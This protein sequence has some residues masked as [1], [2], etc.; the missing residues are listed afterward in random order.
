[1]KFAILKFSSS[2]VRIAASVLYA[3][4]AAAAV[5]PIDARSSAAASMTERSIAAASDA[6]LSRS[7]PSIGTRLDAWAYTAS[8]ESRIVLSDLTAQ[9]KMGERRSAARDCQ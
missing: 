3:L 5:D 7:H 1:M 2:V 4:S 6:R 8:R 9:W